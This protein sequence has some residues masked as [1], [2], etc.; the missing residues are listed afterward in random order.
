[1]TL[2]HRRRHP[3]HGVAVGLDGSHRRRHRPNPDEDAEA[4]A[5]VD[6]EVAVEL[7][8]PASEMKATN[9]PASLVPLA[10]PRQIL[11]VQ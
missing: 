9:P 6:I 10:E 8:L 5:V 7:H 4:A 3:D 11:P 1:M 2:D